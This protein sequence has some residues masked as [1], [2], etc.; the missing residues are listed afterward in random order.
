MVTALADTVP[1]DDLLDLFG[2]RA[3]QPTSATDSRLVAV[4]V[5]LSVFVLLMGLIVT[6]LVLARRRLER[7]RHE[8]ASQYGAPPYPG[9]WWPPYQ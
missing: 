7:K 9:Y 5:T 4:I 3:A 6:F 8:R 2:P 1:S